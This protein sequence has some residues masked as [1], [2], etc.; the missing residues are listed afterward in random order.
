MAP[1]VGKKSVGKTRSK[2]SPP[3]K[4]FILFYLQ[5][6]SLRSQL[7]SLHYSLPFLGPHH[8]TISPPYFFSTD[9]DIII[10]LPPITSPS[11]LYCTLSKRAAYHCD[12]SES[13]SCFFF[14]FSLFFFPLLFL[15]Y[16]IISFS[17][18]IYQLLT[19]DTS[20]IVRFSYPK[21]F[22][23]LFSLTTPF[24]ISTR[25]HNVRDTFFSIP[26]IQFHPSHHSPFLLS[27]FH[28]SGFIALWI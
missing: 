23:L 13:I 6:L 2:K 25:R 9:S 24:F 20:A 19:L 28:S 17:I 18:P 1:R 14:L 22:R 15:P 4:I 10:S 3:P 16:P 27:C 26:P 8:L 7:I 21:T 11:L 5:F 12:L